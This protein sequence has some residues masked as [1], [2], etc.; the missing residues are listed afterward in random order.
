MGMLYKLYVCCPVMVGGVLAAIF[1]NG[2]VAK[3]K[4]GYYETGKI[5]RTELFGCIE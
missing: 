1:S 3:W 5:Y 4:G 2:Y